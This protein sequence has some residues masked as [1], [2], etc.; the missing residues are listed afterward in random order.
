MS[1]LHYNGEAFC[2]RS[3][4]CGRVPK[5]VANTT[6]AWESVTCKR[7]LAYRA[8]QETGAN[9]NTGHGHV[10]PRPDGVK[11]RCGGPGICN[12]CSREQAALNRGAE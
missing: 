10:R 3:P 4:I 8:A 2:L 5:S 12:E 9:P 7:C 11:A 6:T 1:A